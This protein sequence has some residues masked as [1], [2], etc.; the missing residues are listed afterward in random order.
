MRKGRGGAKC[1]RCVGAAG[2]YSHTH[3]NTHTHTHTHTHA[4]RRLV[5]V[6]EACVML[7]PKMR[8]AAARMRGPL[9]AM[10]VTEVWMVRCLSLC[11][12]VRL[13]GASWQ[14]A[15][16]CWICTGVAVGG[17]NSCL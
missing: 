11:T 15:M 7:L 16:K 2:T 5:P 10:P 13:V 17:R 3:T 6:K 12:K 8:C 14:R 4:P 1:R 9:E